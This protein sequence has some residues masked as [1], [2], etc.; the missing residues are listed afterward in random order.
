MKDAGRA[1]FQYPAA[2]ARGSF[3]THRV[4]RDAFGQ[5]K[6]GAHPAHGGEAQTGEAQTAGVIPFLPLPACACCR[7][8]IAAVVGDADNGLRRR[9]RPA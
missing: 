6:P 3:A 7:A 2:G 1:V 8:C 4:T 5:R 9:V